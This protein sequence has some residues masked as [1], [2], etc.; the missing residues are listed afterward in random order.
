MI[1]GETA[2]GKFLLRSYPTFVMMNMVDIFL[3][4]GEAR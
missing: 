1:F 4:K 3:G 2:F